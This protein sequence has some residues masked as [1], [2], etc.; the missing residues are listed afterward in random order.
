MNTEND[1]EEIKREIREVREQDKMLEK[2]ENI[3]NDWATFP[4]LKDSRLT[5]YDKGLIIDWKNKAVSDAKEGL[6]ACED[7]CN[8]HCDACIECYGKGM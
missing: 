1:M 3:Q 7:V 6:Q 5:G 2:E 8:C 4:E